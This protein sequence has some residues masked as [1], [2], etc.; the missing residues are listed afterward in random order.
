MPATAYQQ[1]VAAF[2]GTPET[3]ERSTNPQ[4]RVSPVPASIGCEQPLCQVRMAPAQFCWSAR[5]K[6]T[7]TTVTSA[8]P[9]L[10]RES[11]SFY[12]PGDGRRRGNPADAIPAA[13]RHGTCPERISTHAPCSTG[14]PTR[15]AHTGDAPAGRENG[16]PVSCPPGFQVAVAI[17]SAGA[18]GI[19]MVNPGT[20]D[21]IAGHRDATMDNKPATRILLA[22]ARPAQSTASGGGGRRQAVRAV[23]RARHHRTALTSSSA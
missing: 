14:L 1:K 17:F 20:R 15:K 16:Y 23:V 18:F 2:A 13:G 4:D 21:G 12:A 22:T 10:T 6:C 8:A 11:W 7:C 9:N 3:F 19:T 5:P